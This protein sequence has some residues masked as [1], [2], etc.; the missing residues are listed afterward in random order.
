MGGQLCDKEWFHHLLL[1]SFCFVEGLV[2]EQ[3]RID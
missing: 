2:G 3:S 1:T